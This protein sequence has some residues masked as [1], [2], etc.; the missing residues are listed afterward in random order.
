M[1]LKCLWPVGA[2]RLVRLCSLMSAE[3]PSNG[4]EQ[5]TTNTLRGHAGIQSERIIGAGAEVLRLQLG[6]AT[7]DSADS[8]TYS[9]YEQGK[10]QTHNHTLSNHP[11]SRHLKFR[12][13]SRLDARPSIPHQKVNHPS[14]SSYGC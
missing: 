14:N 6:F 8:R 9:A 7:P 12:L 3:E 2:S 13:S 11:P 5:R 4:L 10:Q 1:K